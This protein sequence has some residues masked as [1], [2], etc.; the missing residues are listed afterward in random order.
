LEVAA[1]GRWEVTL[2]TGDTIAADGV[3]LTG[4]GPRG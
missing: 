4:A 3:V 2:E 1:G